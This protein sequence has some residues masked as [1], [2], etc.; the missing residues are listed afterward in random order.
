MLW[1]LYALFFFLCAKPI[2]AAQGSNCSCL[3]TT[4]TSCALACNCMLLP[5]LVWICPCDVATRVPSSLWR[6]LCWVW[7]CSK[8][9]YCRTRGIVIFHLPIHSPLQSVWLS[10]TCFQFPS[11]SVTR[12]HPT[13]YHQLE[14]GWG[15]LHLIFFLCIVCH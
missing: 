9:L 5:V 4:L 2:T 1:H 13:C 7:W 11:N 12:F 8:A 10:L 14:C 3:I 6:S 15:D